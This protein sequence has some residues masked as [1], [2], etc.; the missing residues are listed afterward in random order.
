[1]IHNQTGAEY[2]RTK[3][4][5]H[6]V[7][8]ETT[9][10]EFIISELNGISRNRAKDILAGHGITV[11]RRET[12]RFDEPLHPGQ[13][14]RVSKHKRSNYLLNKYVKIVYEDKDL[15]V[16]EKAVGILSMPATAKQYSAKQVL[17]EYF[18]KRHFKCTAHTV[19]R[20]DRDTSGLMMYAKN[21]ETAK[22]LEDNWH[23]MVYDRR[24]VAVLNGEMEREGGTVESFLKDNKAYVT[25]SSPTD[26]GGGKWSVT[27]YHTLKTTPRYSLVEFKL[28]TGRKNQIRVHSQ[29]IGHPIVGDSKY[30][31]GYDPIGR[32]CL[33]AYRLHFIHPVTGQRMVFDTPIPKEFNRLVATGQTPEQTT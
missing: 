24:Y 30:G 33:H 3:Y 15:I 16:I 14:V 29:D 6:V 21:I 28:E 27:H 12:T 20:L 32:L 4:S 17:D 1:M 23:E 5:E 10:L 25:F 8:T 2:A 26:P 22:L 9:L 13:V 11:D 7:K 19:H 18:A 31:N